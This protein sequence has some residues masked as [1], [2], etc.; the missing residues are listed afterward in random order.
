M[1]QEE[2]PRPLTDAEL[3][4]LNKLLSKDFPSRN[5]LKAQISESSA[6]PTNDPDN[7]GSVLLSTKSTVKAQVNERIPVE[8]TVN[9]TD[10]VPVNILL[11]VVDGIVNELEILKVD[12]SPLKRPISP[13]DLVLTFN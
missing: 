12:G 7:Y 2:K 13:E 11:H 5:E 1:T 4:I 10:G 6:L 9:D 8:A 3:S